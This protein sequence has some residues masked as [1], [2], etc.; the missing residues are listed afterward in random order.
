MPYWK[1]TKTEILEQIRSRS[2]DGVAPSTYHENAL[3]RT[4]LNH[5]GNWERA[6][7]LAGVQPKVLHKERQRKVHHQGNDL[8]RALAVLL[9][10]ANQYR[11]N[12]DVMQCI[13]YVRRYG[14]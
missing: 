14:A 2:Q 1:Y 7:Q 4:A 13:D 12:V 8:T 10:V 11:E 6:C 3:Y 5:F 9:S